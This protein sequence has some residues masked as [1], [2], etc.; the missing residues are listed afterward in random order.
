MGATVVATRVRDLALMESSLK[1]DLRMGGADADNLTA[2]TLDVCDPDSVNGFST[3]TATGTRA[4][5][6]S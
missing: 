5:S 2:H 3:G 4:H 6:M 1:D